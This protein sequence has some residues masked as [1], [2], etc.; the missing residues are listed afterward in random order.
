MSVH[1]K[2]YTSASNIGVYHV[3]Q[4][5]GR[6]FTLTTKFAFLPLRVVANQTSPT[7]VTSYRGSYNIYSATW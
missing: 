1:T 4:M 3:G 6:L 5:E 7:A 2:M